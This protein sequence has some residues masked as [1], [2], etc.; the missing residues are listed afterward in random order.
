MLRKLV[1][2]VLI[3]MP[4]HSTLAADN[5]LSLQKKYGF[6]MCQ[7]ITPNIKK[8]SQLICS[9]KNYKEYLKDK[10][11]DCTLTN[12]KLDL[13]VMSHQGKISNIIFS[14]IFNDTDYGYGIGGKNITPDLVKTQLSERGL[15]WSESTN[16]YGNVEID[17]DKTFTT[18]I[19]SFTTSPAYMN[20]VLLPSEMSAN[21]ASTIKSSKTIKYYADFDGLCGDFGLSYT[22]QFDANGVIKEIKFSSNIP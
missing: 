19:D 4:T 2:A 9:S 17:F 22:Y 1:L 8:N 12:K 7:K 21:R 10:F 11:Y 3:L 15:V 16:K 13:K 14:K 20:M 5:L 18:D 6:K